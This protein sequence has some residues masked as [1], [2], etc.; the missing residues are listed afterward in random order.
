MNGKCL[1]DMVYAQKSADKF[2]G[3]GETIV[4]AVFAAVALFVV[5]FVVGAALDTAWVY[6]Q[7]GYQVIASHWPF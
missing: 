3:D 5:V 4:P 1:L 6:L 2:A 7:Q